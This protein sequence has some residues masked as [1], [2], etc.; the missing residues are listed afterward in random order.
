MCRPDPPLVFGKPTAP[1]SSS[2]SWATWA[3]RWTV[4][5][6][7]SGPGSRSMRHSSGF[8]VS[9]R[10]LFHG[11]NSTV[12]ICTAHTTDRKSTRLNSS[13]AN[14]SYA[15]F[16]LKKQKPHKQPH[17]QRKNQQLAPLGRTVDAALVAEDQPDRDHQQDHAAGHFERSLRFFFY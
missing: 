6:S 15:D 13:H 14:I 11:W 8:S 17:R 9:D 2:T 16:C 3:T 12:D 1:R 10:R 7:H 5:Q 4:A